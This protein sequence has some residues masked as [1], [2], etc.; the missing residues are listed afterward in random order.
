[1]D[2][3]IPRFTSWSTRAGFKR[4][5]KSRTQG[6][7]RSSI[8]SPRRAGANFAWSQ[9]TGRGCQKQST[10]F[11]SQHNQEEPCVGSTTA[12]FSL[13]DGILIRPLPFASPERLFHAS[14]VGMRGPFDTL[15]ANSQLADYAGH[16]GVRSFN[17][18]G[19]DWPERLK[20]SEVSANFFQ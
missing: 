10:G 9:L 7:R 2:R 13:I 11:W 14:E 6:G 16:L 1:M 8:R 15:R 3:F 12:V 19:H 4:N 17:T 5:G 18:P 20:G